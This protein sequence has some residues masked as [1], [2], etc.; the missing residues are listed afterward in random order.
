MRKRTRRLVVLLGG[1][2]LG[3]GCAST[4]QWDE[5]FQHSTHFA[6]GDHLIFSLRHQGKNPPPR[7][8][9][10]D[11]E[12]ARGQSWWGEPIVVRPEQLFSR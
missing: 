5:W 7:V 4:E 8:S 10:Q 9:V 6:S 3:S 1:A 12:Q 11:V 2:A